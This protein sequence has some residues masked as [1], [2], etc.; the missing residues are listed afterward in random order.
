ME[1][2]NF[3]TKLDIVLSDVYVGLHMLARD[4]L[5]ER[6]KAIQLAMKKSKFIQSLV[7]D[8]AQA[9]IKTV[10]RIRTHF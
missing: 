9:E 5:E 2:L 8:Q 4:Q 1:L 3:D 7:T 6:E 10:R